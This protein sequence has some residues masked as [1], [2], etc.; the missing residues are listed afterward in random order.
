MLVPSD[1]FNVCE[2]QLTVVYDTSETDAAFGATFCE[3]PTSMFK[4]ADT[5]V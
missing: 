1:E 2:W 4:V 3:Q 5:N